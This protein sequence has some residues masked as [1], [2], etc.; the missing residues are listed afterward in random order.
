MP[1]SLAARYSSTR[2]LTELLAAPLSDED[3]VLQSMPSASPTKW[4]RAHTTWF[5]EQFVLLARGE[6]PMDGRYP[7]VFNSYY[8]AVG[9]RVARHRRGLLSRPTAREVTQYRRVIDERMLALIEREGAL[10]AD[11]RAMIE[12]GL[13][14]EEQ[15]QELILTDI[16]HAFSE[17]PLGPVYRRPDVDL[18]RASSDAAEVPLRWHAFAGGL[19]EIGAGAAG[20]AFDNERPRHRVYLAPFELASRLVT[21]GEV[22]AFIAARGYYTPAL[23]LADGYTIAR[24]GGWEAPL[25]TRCD[26]DGYRTFTLRGWRAPADHEPASHLS[27]WEAEA[28]ARFLGARLPTEAEWEHAAS[29]ARVDDGN[30]SDGPLVPRPGPPPRGAAAP[31]A[32]PGQLFGDAWE[33]T[34]SAYEPYPG[35]RPPAGAVGEYNGKFMAQQQVLRGGSCLTP[36]GHVRASY[37][38]FWHPDTRFQVTGVRLARDHGARAP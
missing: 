7:Y 25:H 11:E 2:Q 14:H 38:N 1:S 5:F 16:L 36:R 29:L 21:V 8:D 15:H 26:A 30:F 33:W 20:F 10:S 37:R 28:I 4:H 35:Y 34:R 27:F 31:V 32:T 24:A 13:Q 3:Q 23:W 9:E 6:T 12:L 18:E 17:S 22:R 19:V